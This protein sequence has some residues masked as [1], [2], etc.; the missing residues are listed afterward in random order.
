MQ[1]YQWKQMYGLLKSRIVQEPKNM[2]RILNS[3][4]VQLSKAYL[5]ASTRPLDPSEFR[6][7]RCKH[8]K[9]ESIADI[10]RPYCA[11]HTRSILK[12]AVRKSCTSGLGFFAARIGTGVVFAKNSVITEYRGIVRDAAQ[13]QAAYPTGKAE[14]VL[15]VQLRQENFFIDACNSTHGVARYI[16]EPPK[17]VVPPIPC[18]AKFIKP[19]N[20]GDLIK[21]EKHVLVI[22]Q[23]DIFAGE[24][25]FL[26]Y[27]ANAGY[28]N[29]FYV[30]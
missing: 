13:F 22:A 2:E 7:S 30:E 10:T 12:L 18:N 26:K 3:P 25:I 15:E 27:G 5:E 16:N 23:R 6:V 9:C 28:Y 19:G 21:K 24:E 20:F 29:D 17:N 4:A 1:L 11:D 8:S 14:Y